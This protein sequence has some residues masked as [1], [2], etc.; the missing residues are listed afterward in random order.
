M[1]RNFIESDIEVEISISVDYDETKRYPLILLNDGEIDRL[2]M[3]KAQVIIV[4]LKSANRLD[5]YTPWKA[6]AMRDGALEFGGQADRYHNIVC[7]KFDEY[8][9]HERLK[10]RFEDF[11]RW[12]MT[13]WNLVTV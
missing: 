7:S 2:D 5:D 9:H 11:S 3:L 12:L 1:N 4:G 13:E 6:E 10:E 8:G